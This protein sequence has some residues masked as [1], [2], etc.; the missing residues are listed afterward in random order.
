MNKGRFALNPKYYAYRVAKFHI[1]WNSCRPIDNSYYNSHRSQ[2][3]GHWGAALSF[4]LCIRLNTEI[5]SSID[6]DHKRIAL[7]QNNQ[8]SLRRAEFQE[9]DPSLIYQ[10]N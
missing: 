8:N 4:L 2:T 6:I 5:E 10:M 3:N 7:C 1:S 9:L